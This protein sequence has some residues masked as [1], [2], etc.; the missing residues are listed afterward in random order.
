ML[1]ADIY[2]SRHL[3]IE[4]TQLL[5][6]R[7]WNVI[8][9]VHIMCAARSMKLLGVCPSVCLSVPSFGCHKVLWWVCCCGPS[10]QEILINCCKAGPTAANASNVRLSADVVSWTQSSLKWN[11]TLVL[12]AT[13]THP[14]NGHFSGTTRVCGYQKGKPIW[15]LLKQETVSSSGTSWAICKSAPRSRQITTPAPHHSVFYRPDAL[16]AS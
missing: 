15:I 6:S 10:G 9:T 5:L 4:C 14:F 11:G 1:S 8:D 13:H 3:P 12:T 2:L 7:L 16:P